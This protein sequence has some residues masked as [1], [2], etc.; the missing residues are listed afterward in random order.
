MHSYNEHV[1]MPGS[2]ESAD[3]VMDRSLDLADSAALP[4][5]TRRGIAVESAT[6][7]GVRFDPDFA[8]RP[9]V[10]AAMRDRDDRLSAV[11]GR[12]L[13]ARRSENKML[14]IGRDGGVVNVL[15]GW[16]VEPLILVEGLFD[17]LS[18][19][20]C[21]FACVATIGRWAPWLAEVSAG[22]VVWLAFDRGAPGDAEARRIG[23]RLPAADVR[24]LPP[25]LRCKD[26]NTALVKLGPTRVGRWLREHS[27]GSDTR[28]T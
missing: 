6:A 17:G 28:I 11:H 3:S 21:G 19:A 10:L 8:G 24:R 5:L 15:G 27:A 18:L 2:G 20:V 14:T 26:W 7:V 9:A 1:V 13:H 23:A 25:P 4:Y 12:Y 16:R 22:R